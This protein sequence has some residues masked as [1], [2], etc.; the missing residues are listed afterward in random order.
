MS[1]LQH[2]GIRGACAASRG[3]PG[4]LALTLV[5]VSLAAACGS[6][7]RAS[8]ATPSSG[9][10][11]AAPV[12]GRAARP[13]DATADGPE[14]GAL[15][16]L[17][18]GPARVVW[19]QDVGDGTD[20]DALRDRLMLMALDSQGGDERTVLPNAANYAK[21]LITSDGGRIVFSRRSDEQVLVVNWDGSGLRAVARGFGLAVWRDP[22]S[23]VE[24]VYV[25]TELAE[26]R[27]P[28]YRVVTRYTLDEPTK[29]EGV[30]TEVPIT[31]DT[32]RVS[33][34]G[35][36]AA[37]NIPWP[38]VGVADLARRTWERVGEGCWTSLS[39]DDRYTAW[40]FD[41]A[42]RN[43]T[44][45]DTTRG[46]A[47]WQVA[48]DKAP[49]IDGYEVYHPTWSNHPRFLAMTGP[50]KVGS[51]ENRI[52]GGGAA[53]EVYVGRFSADFRSVEQWAQVTR[54]ARA[55]FLPSV[56]VDPAVVAATD[57]ARPAPRAPDAVTTTARLVADVEL[58]E[59]SRVP[60]PRSILPYR[61]ALAV[62]R[63]RV[64]NV[65]EGAR[66]ADDILVASWVI[67]DGAVVS[68]LRS[69]GA[70]A[71]LTLEPYDRRPDLE[72]E[73]LIRD[74]AVGSFPL[75]V[76]AGPPPR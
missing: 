34:D 49:G 21:P 50:Y 55:D 58:I 9:P 59:A 53:V 12:E 28:A 56:W 7:D 41:G 66:P 48:L 26:R 52:G 25:G 57:T 46:G 36:R 10:A 6:D 14:T 54:N 43:L 45:I 18:G 11:E 51:G 72:G 64:T 68:G 37:A 40:F 5:L 75:F 61:H 39:P 44:L 30:S 47:R 17:T 33:A 13:R 15:E 71:R 74:P 16:R 29:S 1:S 19:V 20:T 67:R 73:R 38:Q 24:W 60:S 65:V 8:R 22:A 35:R 69:R 23:G 3:R 70:R 42:H 4:S 63:Y 32:L 76:E 31:E 62:A 2:G 27:P